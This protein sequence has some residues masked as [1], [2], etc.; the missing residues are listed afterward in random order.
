MSRQL[1]EVL[2]LAVMAVGGQGG[3]V[4]TNWIETL[5]RAHGYVCQAT[6]VAGVAQRTGATIYYIEMAPAGDQ[7]P[8]F[9]LAPAAGDVDVV[10]AAEM[11]EAGRAVIRGFVTPDRTTLI[12]S[13]HRALSVS[14]K[15]VP[16]D[17]IASSAEVRAA[18]ELAAQQLVMFDLEKTA[19]D[20]GSVI[21]AS[22]FGALAATGRLPFPREAFEDAIRAGGKGVEP[23]L[24]A[25]T[26]QFPRHAD[27]NTRSVA[28]ADPAAVPFPDLCG[29]TLRCAS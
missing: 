5:A 13:T 10:V 4:L 9:S 28:S 8:V 7:T 14:E 1:D 3:G 20:N 21:S 22:L 18:V 6:S 12:A 17:G 19:I 15:T 2:K 27:E 29:G 23:S 26:R 24:R 11:M 16:G 25:S